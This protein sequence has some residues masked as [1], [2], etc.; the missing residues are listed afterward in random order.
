MML[1]Y[2]YE[3]EILGGV[4][5]PRHRFSAALMERFVANFF[6]VLKSLLAEPRIAVTDIVLR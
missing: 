6:V 2:E 4:H 5:F 1:L 3:T